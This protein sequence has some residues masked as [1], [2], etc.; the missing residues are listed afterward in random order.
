MANKSAIIETIAH[1]KFIS[2]K[3]SLVCVSAVW[4][5]KINQACDLVYG[6]SRIGDLSKIVHKVMSVAVNTSLYDD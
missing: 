5:R 4:D 6:Q 1:P 3:D 2:V